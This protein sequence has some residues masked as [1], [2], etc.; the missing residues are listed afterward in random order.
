[1][2]D[3][4]GGN[5]A[6]TVPASFDIFRENIEPPTY[7]REAATARKD[8]L[9]S[10]LS[11]DFEILEA[12]P[13]GS[14]P[15]YTGIKKYSDLDIMIA[16]HYGKHVEG[17]KPSQ[18]L[19]A[20]RESLSDYKPLRR[21]GQ[22]VTVYYSTWP[23][24]VD[25]VPVSRVA[26]NGKLL[27]YNI[28]D[29]NTETWIPSNPN[30]HDEDLTAKNKS[31][32]QEFKRIIKMVKWWNKRHSDLLQSFHLEILAYYS[33]TGAFSEYSW[34][35]RMFFDNAAKF[36]NQPLKHRFGNVDDYL[37]YS[38]RQEAQ[39][40]LETAKDQAQSAWYKT[41]G[42]NIDHKGAIE[43]WRQIFGEEFP[44]YG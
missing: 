23:E 21:N 22:A 30:L 19:Q 10:L 43:I 32:G 4:I 15:R 29:M 8:W 17:K 13:T 33:L 7:E 40:R 14:L 44:A 27:Y 37:S 5:M 41:Y 24:Y 1:V 16:L 34:N 35:I 11:K 39:K 28:P 20:V 3:K 38:N 12:F 36:I 2:A 6:Y 18:V 42:A 9:V 26:D 25:I 31:F